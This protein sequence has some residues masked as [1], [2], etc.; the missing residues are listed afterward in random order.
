MQY[1]STAL[2]TECVLLMIF[3]KAVVFLSNVYVQFCFILTDLCCLS[4]CQIS[5]NSNGAQE[6]EKMYSMTRKLTHQLTHKFKE[7]LCVVWCCSLNVHCSIHSKSSLRDFA[8][9]VKYRTTQLA[10]TVQTSL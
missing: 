10:Q 2:P 8:L 4:L 1:N 7:K 9:L 6:Q 3:A 5:M